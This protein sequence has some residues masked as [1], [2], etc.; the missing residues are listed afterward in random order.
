[1]RE[2]QFRA[3]VK[4]DLEIGINVVIPAGEWLEWDAY[5]GPLGH[6]KEHLNLDSVG[7]FTGIADKNGKKIYE[8]DIIKVWNY[9]GA[10]NKLETPEIYT[11]EYGRN[12]AFLLHNSGI[13][14]WAG[15]DAT[16][17]CKYEVIGNIYNPDLLE[18]QT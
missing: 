12:A 16:G 1:M 10:T 18:H 7:Q 6:I 2:L 15:F 11:I 13:W 5:T 8:G 14:P 9:N 17:R 4:K 3:L